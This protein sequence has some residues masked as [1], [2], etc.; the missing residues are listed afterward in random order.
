MRRPWEALAADTKVFSFPACPADPW[1]VAEEGKE[2][3]LEET[4]P[5]ETE[6]VLVTASGTN[7]FCLLRGGSRNRGIG[8]GV[9]PLFFVWG[10]WH[11][12][13]RLKIPQAMS[14]QL[15]HRTLVDDKKEC[16][17]GRAASALQ[18]QQPLA[19]EIGNGFGQCRRSIQRFG[20]LQADA[21]LGGIT[22]ESN[23]DIVED[24]DVV[25]EKADGL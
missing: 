15:S 3:S 12:A 22:A 16:A 4:E 9:R 5:G 11:A 8:Q 23:V 18:T 2:T 14:T 25:A 6:Q 19:G 1:V 7:A 20:P 10:T 21:E 13:D 17:G 24:L